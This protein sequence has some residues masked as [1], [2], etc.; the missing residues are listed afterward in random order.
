MKAIVYHRYGSPDV[1]QYE[2]IDKPTPAIDDVLI[3]VAAASVNPYDWHFMRGEPYL[4]RLMAGLQAPKNPR[5][6]ADVAGTVA[7]VGD[8]VKQLKPGDSVFGT[9]KGAFAEYVCAR[10][11]RLVLKPESVT[12]EQ[13][14]SVPIAAITALQALRDKGRIQAGDKVLINGAAGGVGTF[15]VQI[16]KYFGAEVTAVCSGG[17]LEMVRGIGADHAIDYRRENFTTGEKRY[18][19]IL[20]CVGNHLLTACRRVLSPQGVYV[21]AGGGTGR[22]MLGPLLQMI[23]LPLLSWTG[24]RKFVG[25]LAK[26]NQSDLIFLG[27]LVASGKVKPVIDRQYG[28][29]EIPEA[30]RYLEEGHARGKVV[31][32]VGQT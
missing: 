2:E 18:D 20:D 17:K 19:I 14:A 26:M 7:S 30:I 6:G 27:E 4:L 15:A 32:R 10:E 11:S 25:I 12:F 21:G 31:I 24:S 5:L 8:H 28:L 22:W 9:A 23:A 16:A 1:L 3:K 13:A 29:S